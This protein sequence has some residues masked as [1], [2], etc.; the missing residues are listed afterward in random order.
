M[1]A[2]LLTQCWSSVTVTSFYLC[3]CCCRC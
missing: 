1:Y 3:C 2:K